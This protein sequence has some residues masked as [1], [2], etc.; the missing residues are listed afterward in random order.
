M[1]RCADIAARANRAVCAPD[2][3]GG[4]LDPIHT[5]NSSFDADL[6]AAARWAPAHLRYDRPQVL[7]FGELTWKNFERLAIGIAGKAERV[8][9]VARYGGS[10]Q[11][12][13]DDFS[14]GWLLRV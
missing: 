8:E 2:S 14:L 3:K 11:A 6:N 10:G 9:H 1:A 12:N 4:N 13:R 5:R 7:P